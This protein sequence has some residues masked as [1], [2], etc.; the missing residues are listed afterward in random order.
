MVTVLG[1]I[2]ALMLGILLIARSRQQSA[3]AREGDRLRQLAGAAFEGLVIERNGVVIDANRRMGELMGFDPATLVGHAFTR[4][5]P[6]EDGSSRASRAG[7]R[8][9]RHC[10]GHL[11]PVELLFR[12]VEYDGAPATAIAVRGLSRQHGLPSQ[13][14]ADFD[15]LTGLAS[16]TLLLDRLASALAAAGP[17]GAVAVVR[18]NL[19]RFGAVNDRLGKDAGDKLL[20]A[21]GERLSGLVRGTDTLA[22]LG[23]DEFAVVLPSPDGVP[24]I[25]VSLASRIVSRLGQPFGIDG[26]EVTIGVSAGIAVHPEDGDTAEGLLRCADVAMCCAKAG[27][28]GAFRLFHPKMELQDC[29]APGNRPEAVEPA[30]LQMHG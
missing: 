22:R 12:P 2:T 28:R 24:S 11:V 10:D 25:A 18:L 26:H 17:E 7:D 15:A 27:G 6:P 8:V 4:I 9:L 23:A 16:R 29:P 20:V 3:L 21:V 13:P 1:C 14:L 30:V 5:V 19:D